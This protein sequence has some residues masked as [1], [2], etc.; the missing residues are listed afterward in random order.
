MEI[1]SCIFCKIVAQ[2]IPSKI[3]LQTSDILVIPDIH[4]QASIHYLILPKRHIINLKECMPSDRN[5]LGDMLLVS[6]ELS[7]SLPSPQEYRLSVNNG[8]AAGQRVFHMHMHFLA[9]PQIPA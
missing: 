1:Q 4:P 7:E 3:I 5:L 9:G 8:Y 2:E 6:K